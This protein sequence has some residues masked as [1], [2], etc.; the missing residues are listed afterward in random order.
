MAF[1]EAVEETVLEEV[2]V[3]AT[4]GARGVWELLGQGGPLLGRL[5]LPG[6]RPWR[7]R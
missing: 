2:A 6:P 3:R 5:L 7:R 1:V 4:V